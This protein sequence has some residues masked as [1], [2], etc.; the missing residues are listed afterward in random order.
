MKG[1]LVLYMGHPC[2]ASDI[3][4]LLG[5]KQEPSNT[6]YISFCKQKITGSDCGVHAIQVV[7]LIMGRFS[8]RHKAYPRLG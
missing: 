4:T 8:Q 1:P 5:C 7:L 2:C 3:P 6:Q